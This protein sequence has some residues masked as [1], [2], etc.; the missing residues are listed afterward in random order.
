MLSATQK[1]RTVS[2]LLVESDDADR[3]IIQN[4]LKDQEHPAFKLECFSSLQF[5]MKHLHHWEGQIILA[6][7]HLQDSNGLQTFDLLHAVA[8]KLPI[9]VLSR[10]EDE[11]EALDAVR[12]GAQD[13]LV[14]SKLNSSMLTRVLLYAIERKK[15][16]EEIYL[17]EAKYRGIFENSAVA[18]TFVGEDERI[19]SWN[20]F[21]EEM[22]DISEKDLKNRNVS[23][24]YPEAEWKKIR[25]LSIRQKGNRHHFETRMIKGNGEIIDVDLSLSVLRDADGKI[26]GTIGFMQDIT[27]RKR[28]ENVKEEF[29]ATVSHEMR[30]PMTVIREGVSQ[31]YDGILGP[32]TEPQNEILSVTLESIDRLGRIIN[33]LLDISKLN[34][35]KM[36]AKKQKMDLTEVLQT[37]RTAFEP[38]AK[39]KKLHLDVQCPKAPIE[40]Y[41]DKDKIIQ[42]FTN[43]LG[44]AFKFTKQ[45]KITVEASHGKDCIECRVTDTGR[46]FSQE[47]LS[48]VFEKFQQFDR[49]VGPGD[50]GTGLGLAICKGIVELHQGRIWVES[51]FGKGSTFIFTL[52][53]FTGEK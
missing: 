3:Q 27:E 29:L 30:T 19:I 9:V 33:D 13:Y 4:L 38:L 47:D 44:N 51:E 6:A 26:T 2:I 39:E 7:L 28:L 15:A 48:K 49:E 25:E 18:I 5:A 50:K 36:V 41:A 37:L 24:L 22:L 10:L 1:L 12:K 14:K 40:L 46:G 43:L 11:K 23:S 52:P 8:P 20:K 42:V 53:L 31:I 34:A 45:G 32:T 35:G 16:Q 17:A 21:S